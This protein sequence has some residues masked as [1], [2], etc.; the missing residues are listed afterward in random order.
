MS[1][2]RD[3]AAEKMQATQQG[4]LLRILGEKLDGGDTAFMLGMK[5]PPTPILAYLPFPY[6]FSPFV[7]GRFW[8]DS[9]IRIEGGWSFAGRDAQEPSWGDLTIEVRPVEDPELLAKIRE[10]KVGLGEWE[11]KF[12]RK[13]MDELLEPWM[14]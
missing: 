12:I 5:G 11:T 13:K 1:I 7:F 4:A 8:V 2:P 14:L 9:L 6:D 10:F 3:L